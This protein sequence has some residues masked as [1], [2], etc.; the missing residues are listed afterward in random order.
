[1]LEGLLF[2]EGVDQLLEDQG[3]GRNSGI[4]FL[5]RLVDPGGGQLYLVH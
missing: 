1:M 4:D 5:G 3:G 2:F